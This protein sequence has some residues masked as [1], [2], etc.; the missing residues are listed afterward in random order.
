MLGIAVTLELVAAVAVTLVIGPPAKLPGVALSS[1]AVFHG[2]RALLIF[3]A[4]YAITV[5]LL[6]AFSGSLA[7]KVGSGGIEF[8]AERVATVAAEEIAALNLRLADQ[9][10]L[11]TTLSLR[12]AE[13]ASKRH[14]TDTAMVRMQRAVEEMRADIGRLERPF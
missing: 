6:R 4:M 14:E 2:Y 3:G 5:V 11:I 10:N 12:V 1:V 13:D 9:A 8:A 7:V